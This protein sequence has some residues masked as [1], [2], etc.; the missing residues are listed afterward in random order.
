[1]D[2]LLLYIIIGVSYGTIILPLD[3]TVG[4]I[5]SFQM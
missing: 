4:W 2:V 5:Q 1:M 3:E